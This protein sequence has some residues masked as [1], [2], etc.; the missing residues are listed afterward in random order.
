MDNLEIHSQK[1]LTDAFGH[2]MVCMTTQR[3]ILRLMRFPDLKKLKTP[4][5][6]QRTFADLLCAKMRAHDPKRYGSM[7]VNDLLWLPKD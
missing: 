2:G 1:S 3:R 5:Q 4:N 7:S 6:S